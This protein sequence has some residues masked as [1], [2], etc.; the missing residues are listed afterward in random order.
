VFFGFPWDTALALFI[1]PM[2]IAVGL[3]WYASVDPRERR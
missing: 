3:I 1:V 2:L